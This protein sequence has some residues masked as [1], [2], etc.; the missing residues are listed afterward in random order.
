MSDENFA[1]N[2]IVNLASLPDFLRTP[3][4]KKR[5]IEFF[6]K[7]E[8]DKKEIINNALE[9]G[10]T[11]PFLN[12]SKLF[13][14]WLKIIANL[15]EE[16][17]EGMFV[18]Y[19]TQSLSSPEKLISFNLDGILEIFLELEEKEKEIISNTIKRIIRNLND[20]E[21]KRILI[22]I[23]NNAKNHLKI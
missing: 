1:G 15:S 5:M 11:I 18:A 21:K 7:P 9:A 23:P 17:R 8:L 16:H 20:E 22:M 10:P 3:I 14:S 19:I 13:K 12:F 6:S 4:L 2:I